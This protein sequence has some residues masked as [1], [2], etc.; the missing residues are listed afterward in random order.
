MLVDIMDP[1]QT[2]TA[3]VPAEL[4]GLN[5]GKL[6]VS[7]AGAKRIYALET[8]GLEDV[9]AWLSGFRHF[10]A[11]KFAALETEIARGKRQRTRK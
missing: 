5:I 4:H 3:A 1:A 8:R 2:A 10:W 9:D 11:P 7:A 6:L